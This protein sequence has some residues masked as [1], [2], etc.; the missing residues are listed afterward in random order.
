[1][2]RI[3]NSMHVSHILQLF[4]NPAAEKGIKIAIGFDFNEYVSITTS[5][6]TKGPTYP[7]FRPDRSPIKLGEG[8]WIAGVDKNN[9]VALLAAARLY[10]LSHSNFAEHLQS[11]KAF[12]TDPSVHAHPQ[13][14][15]TCTA[16]SAKKITGKV[17]YYGD[18]WVR[19]DFRGRGIPKI[20]AGIT[21]GLSY[22]MWAPDFLCGIVA[23]WQVDKGFVADCGYAHCEPG[24][25]MTHLVGNAIGGEDWLIWRTGEE[26][27]SEFD[28]GNEGELFL[29]L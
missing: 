11:L 8:Y 21:H 26:L 24:V 6:P 12:Y 15:C 5:T 17:V 19:K 7:N 16:P 9:Q 28:C 27:R 14:R 2:T 20:T 23:R 4:N 29:A 3:A 1:M 25:C 18:L 22:A 13:D 10:D